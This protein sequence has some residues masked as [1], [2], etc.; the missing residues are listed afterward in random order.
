[1]KS[2]LVS[3]VAAVVLVGCTPSTTKPLNK[4]WFQYNGQQEPGFRLWERDDNGIWTETYPSGHQS[5]FKE[6]GI[7][8]VDGLVGDYVVKLSGDI[9]KTG[10]Q[11]GG[12]RVFIPHYQKKES[13]LYFSQKSSGNW[14]DWKETNYSI[15]VLTTRDGGKVEDMPEEIAALLRKQGAKTAEEL[16]TPSRRSQAAGTRAPVLSQ[17][18][19][20][21]KSFPKTT[22]ELMFGANP[23]LTDKDKAFLSAAKEGKLDEVKSLLEEG[24]DIDCYDAYACTALFWAAANNHINNV[25]L[26]IDKGAY[27]DAGAG[28]G[29]TPLGRAAYEGHVEVVELLI[30]HGANVNAKDGTGGSVLDAA[31]DSVAE[32]LRKN[33]A[34]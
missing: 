16:N 2:I 19:A 6:D 9:E 27:I 32:I 31:D 13:F 15:I 30:E 26:L 10:T 23:T 3:I 22:K 14:T 17:K 8:K 1:M 34:R 28:I 18:N 29:G 24:V 21:P 20:R 33:G 7:D 25:E 11:D 12:F 4:F 5:K